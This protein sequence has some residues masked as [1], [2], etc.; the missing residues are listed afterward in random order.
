MIPFMI[1][2]RDDGMAWDGT[3]Q[4]RN[5]GRVRDIGALGA[6]DVCTDDLDRISCLVVERVVYSFYGLSIAMAEIQMI[7]RV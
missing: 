2:K 7:P 1:W 3:R 4:G 6:M 5:V